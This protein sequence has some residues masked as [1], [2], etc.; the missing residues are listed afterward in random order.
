MEAYA[1]LCSNY[2]SSSDE[3]FL[4]GYS[5]GAFIARC[6]A[7]LTREVGLLTKWGLRHLRRVFST[8]KNNAW[9]GN[10]EDR[11]AQFDTLQILESDL[12]QHVSIKACALYDT[13]SAVGANLAFVH[14]TLPDNIN[15]AFQAI[16]FHERRKDF[17]HIAMRTS[18]SS[19][20]HLEQ[21]WFA[22]YHGDIGGGRKEGTL[23]HFALIWIISKLS[24]HGKLKFDTKNLI[25]ETNNET[26]WKIEPKDTNSKR[27]RLTRGS[28]RRKPKCQFWTQDG[29]VKVQ[30]DDPLY[31]S[32][33]TMHVS[34]R[35]IGN[36]YYSKSLKWPK[37]SILHMVPSL[38]E[39]LD[40]GRSRPPGNFTRKFRWKRG[41]DS[42]SM[43]EGTPSSMELGL[44]YTWLVDEK[45]RAM[46]QV[47]INAM[48]PVN[49]AAS[50][51]PKIMANFDRWAWA[52]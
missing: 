51:I 49:E 32:Q 34:M 29:L 11:R 13:V 35:L 38:Q 9:R 24:E 40:L 25:D 12:R 6:L 3:I 36:K 46:S 21:C 16:S 1:F 45:R 31:E 15:F 20:T 50:N 26:T 28:W 42:Y 23:A 8:W 48:A 18:V 14:S 17:K 43:E 44:L 2:T 19:G 47:P 7:Q 4:I 10:L 5:R 37:P 39:Q 41:A 52:C 33:E 22:G 27:W 30:P